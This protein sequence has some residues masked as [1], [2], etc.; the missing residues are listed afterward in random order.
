MPF[1]EFTCTPWNPRIRMGLPWEGAPSTM[2]RITDVAAAA[3]V[4]PSTVSHALNGKR[5]ISPATR[6][7]VLNAIKKLGYVPN[8]EA[9]ALKGGSTG[10]IGFYGSDI[11]ELFVAKNIRGVESVARANGCHLMLA[12]GPEFNHDIHEALSFL[13][14][15][16]L[17]GLILSFAFLELTPIDV[18]NEVDCP[19]VV[20]NRVAAEGCHCILPDNAQGGY[21]A[22]CHL[23]EMGASRLAYIGGPRNR[24][25]SRQRQEGF[26][27]ALER[28]GLSLDKRHVFQGSYDH[29]AGDRGLRSLLNADPA[30]DGVFCVNDFVA[31]GAINAAI[32]L[33]VR[34]PD[35]LKIVGYDD[36]EFSEF[37]PLPITTFAQ[38]L[39]EIGRLGAELLFKL[40]RGETVQEQAH[41]VR[42]RLIARKSSAGG[43]DSDIVTRTK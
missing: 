20:I 12:S 3:G 22:A 5:P 19:V 41:L 37:W 11:T 21:D 13:K 36:R 9:K 24:P 31:A 40:L 34:V 8:A 38:P 1:L 16:R 33:G 4:A 23:V 25:A 27:R 10:I 7:R 39:E 15:R 14:R 18:S 28:E 30:I 43:T 2:V 17:D 32:D 29:E 26:A 42:S 35:D 6:R